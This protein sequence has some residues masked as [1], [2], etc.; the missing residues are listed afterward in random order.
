[1]TVEKRVDV[2]ELALKSLIEQVVA[3]RRILDMHLVT[4][5]RLTEVTERLSQLKTR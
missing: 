1:M 2:L 3:N 4:L 5:T